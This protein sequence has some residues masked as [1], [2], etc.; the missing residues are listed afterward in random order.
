MHINTTLLNSNHPKSVIRQLNAAESLPFSE[1]LSAEKIVNSLRDINYRERI[2][3]P[4]VIILGFLSQ[5]LNSDKSCQAAVARIITF[6][7]SQ[8]KE[9]PSANT[10]AYSKA[11]SRLSKDT[12]SILAKEN[13][14]QMEAEVPSTWL[15]RGK[16]YKTN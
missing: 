14:K 4:D 2:F 16:T 3:T 12:L 8:G 9:A 1:I 6:F 5:V 11:R 7:I 13:A 15:W 10:A